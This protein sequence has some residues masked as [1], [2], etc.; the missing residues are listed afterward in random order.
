MENSSTNSSYEF[1]ANQISSHKFCNQ[2]DARHIQADFKNFSIHSV[3]VPA[4]GDIPDI[5]NSEKNYYLFNIWL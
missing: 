5:I 1:E 2:N 3:Y 4:G